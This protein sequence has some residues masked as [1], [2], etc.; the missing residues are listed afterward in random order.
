MSVYVTNALSKQL[1]AVNNSFAYTGA[2]ANGRALQANNAA[3]NF[4]EIDYNNYYST[5]QFVWF[6]T[7]LRANLAALQTSREY[8][9]APH[10][11]N[12]WSVDPM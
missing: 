3:S 9:M 5:G 11:M 10:D 4:I 12:S 6:N 2:T 7:A 1:R 8:G